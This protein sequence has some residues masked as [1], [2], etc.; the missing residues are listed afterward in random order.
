VG[1]PEGEEIECDSER[2][3][4]WW[5]YICGASAFALQQLLIAEIPGYWLA[6]PEVP[7]RGTI[8]LVSPCGGIV[9]GSNVEHTAQVHGYPDLSAGWKNQ[10]PML[11]ELRLRV[12]AID[13]IGYGRTVSPSRSD[14]Q[15]PW[16]CL[17]T[18]LTCP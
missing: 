16:L 12:V 6:E 2:H 14:R 9:V 7:P 13:C 4:L 3:Q 15:A 18:L 17:L 10:I 5:V 1:G 11:L 8:F